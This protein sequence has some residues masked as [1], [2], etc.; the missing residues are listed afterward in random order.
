M[1]YSISETAKT[2][3]VCYNTLRKLIN[4]K[5]IPYHKMSNKIYFTDEDIA[6][7]DSC[8]EVKAESAEQA[9]NSW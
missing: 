3:G 5:K 7:F 6:Q 4:E 8:F 9:K 2:I 1:R